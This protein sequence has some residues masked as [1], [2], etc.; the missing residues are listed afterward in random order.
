[1]TE[2]KTLSEVETDVK[3]GEL[4]GAL[5]EP[6][7]YRHNET[8]YLIIAGSGP[9]DRDGNQPSIKTDTYKK[10]AHALSKQNIASY[11]YDKKGVG[12][13]KVDGLKE[14]NL[15]IDTYIND[16]VYVID[17]LRNRYPTSKVGVIGHSEGGLIGLAAGLKTDIDTLVLV[18]TP[19][20]TIDQIILEQ[21]S[22][23]APQL[24]NEAKA[25]VDALKQGENVTHISESFFPLFRPS[26]QPYMNSLLRLDPCSLLSQRK[27]KTLIVQGEHDLQVTKEDVLALYA[28]NEK[29]VTLRLIGSMNHVLVAANNNLEDNLASY[30]NPSLAI[31]KELIN[32]IIE[33]T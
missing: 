22:A 19:G 2:N 1:M 23:R 13:S 20:R 16:A 31:H 9:T 29:Q 4:T 21:L 14:E 17:W 3:V 27:G 30:Q 15:T 7:S 6:K 28:D 11:R 18:A 33:Y 5:V 26:A 10:L 24:V 32:S 8:V 12:E 25:I